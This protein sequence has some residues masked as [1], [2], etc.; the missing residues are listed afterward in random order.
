L[1]CRTSV[2]YSQEHSNAR[3]LLS[4]TAANMASHSSHSSLDDYYMRQQDEAEHRFSKHPRASRSSLVPVR[5]PSFSS[6]RAQTPSIPSQSPGAVRRKPL[7]ENASPRLPSL[8]Y[9]S[10]PTADGSG[11]DVVLTHFH[12][13]AAMAESQPGRSATVSSPPLTEPRMAQDLELLVRDR[14]RSL[15]TLHMY[16][17]G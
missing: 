13:S 11:D 4:A 9:H 16:A 17:P 14:F 12:H 5:V 7:P 10:L 8:S 6:F 3:P 2:S 1:L 15:S